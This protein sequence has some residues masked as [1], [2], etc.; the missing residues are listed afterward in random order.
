[1]QIRS[2]PSA[3]P[4]GALAGAGLPEEEGGG[5]CVDDNP[6]ASA[7]QELSVK[8]W[9]GAGAKAGGPRVRWSPPIYH[10]SAVSY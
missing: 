4:A 1:M 8:G 2:T 7:L 6:I 5:G 9:T 3:L 10:M